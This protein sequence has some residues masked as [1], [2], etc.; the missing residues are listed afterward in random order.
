ME[1]VPFQQVT[2]DMYQGPAS[3]RSSEAAQSVPSGAGQGIDSASLMGQIERSNQQIQQLSKQAATPIAMKSAGQLPD[4]MTRQIGPAPQTPN[5]GRPQNKGQAMG[6]MIR[7][8]GN[9]ISK[10]ITA[11]KE[12]KQEQMVSVGTKFLTAQNAKN[13]AQQALDVAMKNNDGPAIAAAKDVLSKNE[14]VLQ[15]ITSD[16]K[17]RDLLAKGFNFNHIDPSENK[18]EEH[19]A[20]KKAAELVQGNAEK[21]AAML[22]AQQNYKAG[23]NQQ[24]AKAFQAAYEK[25]QPTVMGQNTGAQSQLAAMQAQRKELMD[26][27]RIVLPE[28]IKGDIEMSKEA[29]ADAREVARNNMEINKAVVDSNR[30]L[31]VQ[32]LKNQ[33]DNVNNS[34]A[35]SLER[36]RE[37]SARA[38]ALL[39]QNNPLEGLKVFNT[40][41]KDF[42]IAKDASQK[43]RESINKELDAKPS[44]GRQIELRRQLI[45]IDQTDQKADTNFNLNKIVIARGAK[46]DIND[47]R[48]NP[49]V[50]TVQVG[51]GDTSATSSKQQQQQP[52]PDIDPRTGQPFA[53]H[54]NAVSRSLVKGVYGTRALGSNIATATGQAVDSAGAAI[55]GTDSAVQDVF[56]TIDDL[57]GQSQYTKEQGK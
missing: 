37:G 34:A 24:G 15:S 21:K 1:S 5:Q 29:H 19:D 33:Q 52:S 48:L 22:K 51:D 8:A 41:A 47:P 2:N 46:V 44:A 23:L 45:A 11:E 17:N 10:V 57:T 31:Q 9:A 54:H 6:D 28:Q 50:P 4:S 3:A 36:S 43:Q 30:A 12:H 53:A 39:A 55:Q 32:S 35:A 16:K 42:Q 49:Q 20:M 27:L 14:T 40:A 13:E 26:T 25:S 18:T 38:L 7:S 56:D